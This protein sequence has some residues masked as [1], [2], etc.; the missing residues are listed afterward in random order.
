MHGNVSAGTPA[1]DIEDVYPLSPLQQGLL[2]HT[3]LD[4]ESGMYFEQLQWELRGALDAE[5]LQR[6]WQEALDRHAVLRTSIVSDEGEPLHVIR[7]GI[8]LPFATD[9]LRG[10]TPREQEQWLADLLAADRARGFDPQTAPLMRL[11]LVR[12]GNETHVLVWSFHHLLLDGWSSATLL[13]EIFSRYGELKSGA[14]DVKPLVSRPYREYVAWLRG[15]DLAAAEEYWRGALA[16][17]DTATPLGLDRPERGEDVAEG[18]AGH[19]LPIPQEVAERLAALP[20]S[21]R[22]TANTVAQAAWALLLTRISGEHDVVFGATVSGRPAELPGVE[23]MVG[24][25]INT[26]PVRVRIDEDERVRDLLARLQREQAAARDFEH[27]SLDAI[28][29][30]ADVPSGEPLFESLFAYEN[31]PLGAAPDNEES[32]GLE[33]VS[34]GAQAHTNYPL[35]AAIVPGQD[36]TLDLFYD[37][38]SFEPEVIARLAEAYVRL[39]GQLVDV[40]DTTVSDL[41]VLSEGERGRLVVGWNETGVVVRSGLVHEWVLGQSGG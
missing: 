39:L 17:F 24:L 16:G 8:T 14:T 28:R 31:Y 15:R 11:H 20:Q 7:Q 9:D 10:E 13:G 34:K 27:T 29:G 12:T 21:H 4:P 3:L 5:L 26:L 2:F 40:P 1:G 30:W 33:F 23:N 37:R 18:R 22:L 32:I 35:T 25:F 19:R 36:L 6:A 41:S 38:R